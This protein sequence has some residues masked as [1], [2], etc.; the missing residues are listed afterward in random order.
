MKR[1]PILFILL[2]FSLPVIGQKFLVLEKMGT[3][4]R[5]E[6]QISQKMDLRLD[7]DDYF[8]RVT[9]LDLTDSA[10]M[11]ENLKIDFSSIQAVKLNKSTN[12]F[13]YSGPL[14]MVAGAALIIFDVVNQTAVQGGEYQSST[15]VYVTSSTLFAVGAAFTFAGR[16]KVR[17]KKWWRFR[18]VEVN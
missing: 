2:V 13:K 3:K 11:A 16:D 18:T 14:L 5:F 15:G 7:S 9:I 6:F 12:F 17:M 8:T 4:K 10:I 1:L